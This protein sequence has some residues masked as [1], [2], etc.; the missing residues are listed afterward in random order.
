M[1][2]PLCLL[3]RLVLLSVHLDQELK[4][5]KQKIQQETLRGQLMPRA[6]QT[7]QQVTATCVSCCSAS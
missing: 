6:N 5:Q 7:S 2:V 3:E 4:K 1:C